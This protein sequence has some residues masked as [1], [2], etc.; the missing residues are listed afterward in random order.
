MTDEEEIDAFIY[1]PAPTN[2]PPETVSATQLGEWIGLSANRV[3]RLARDGKIPRDDKN[4]FELRPA[5]RAYVETLREGQLGRTNTNPELQAAKVRQATA[6][7]EKLELANAKARDDLLDAADVQSTWTA[8]I[9]DL[10]AAL[11]AIPQR[12]SSTLGLDRR[13]TQQLDSEMRRALE[14]L[15]D[16]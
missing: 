13:A 5:I 15:A 11:L 16:G 9:I 1:G 14:V 10:R 3:N 4:R 7:A 8:T 6:T 12:L 2:K